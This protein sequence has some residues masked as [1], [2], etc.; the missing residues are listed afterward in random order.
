[1]FKLCPGATRTSSI[2]NC[3]AQPNVGFK[4]Q[5]EVFFWVNKQERIILPTSKELCCTLGTLF[6]S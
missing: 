6:S 3:I 1:M 2:Y 4:Y 5:K